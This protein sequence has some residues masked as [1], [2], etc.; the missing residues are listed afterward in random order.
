MQRKRGHTLVEVVVAAAI[1]A[2]LAGVA[3]GMLLVVQ[4]H[5]GDA[6]AWE[7]ATSRSREV[8]DRLAAEL[9]VA[10]LTPSDLDP[11]LP[12]AVT[13]LKYRRVVGYDESNDLILLDPPRAS[14]LFHELALTADGRIERR[15]PGGTLSLARGVSDL[16]F[17]LVPPDELQIQVVVVQKD[18]QGQDIKVTAQRTIW[19]QNAVQDGTN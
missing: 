6:A 13:S 7:R 18:A 10:N 2:V 8:L 4:E 16:R 1:G 14:G 12:L 15:S 5:A 19:L 3:L 17:T 11:D 9:R